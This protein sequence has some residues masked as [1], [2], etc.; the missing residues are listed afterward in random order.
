VKAAEDQANALRE[1]YSARW[2]IWWVPRALDGSMTWC[3][4][5]HGDH[6]LNVVTADS[7]EE[8]DEHIRLREEDLAADA[9]LS[10]QAARDLTDEKP[11][12]T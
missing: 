3:A 11:E 4:R 8:L 2:E 6:L 10:E 9:A 5:L 7:A 1:K 12:A